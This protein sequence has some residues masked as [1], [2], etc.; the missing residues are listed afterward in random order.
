MGEKN[1]AKVNNVLEHAS[2]EFEQK[3]YSSNLEL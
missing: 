3:L 1:C 2:V